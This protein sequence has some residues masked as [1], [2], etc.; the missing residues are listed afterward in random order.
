[1]KLR[2]W[3]WIVLAVCAIVSLAV[4]YR[5]HQVTEGQE[6]FERLGC[7]NCHLA[8]GAPSLEH[9]ARKYDRA[10]L[11]E[12]VVDPEAIYARMGRKPLN[13]GYP[14]MTRSPGSRRDA[15]AISYFLSAQ[16]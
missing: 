15:E 10:T 13:H 1:M 4:L 7:S 9:V 2:Y 14:P 16:R 8:G 12:F 6:A 5:Y 11:V 3:H